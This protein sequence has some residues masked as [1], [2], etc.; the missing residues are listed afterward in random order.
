ML[1]A[2]FWRIVTMETHTTVEEGLL[3]DLDTAVVVMTVRL[4]NDVQ[5]KRFTVRPYRTGVGASIR[6]GDVRDVER[7]VKVTAVVRVVVFNGGL[8]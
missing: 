2:Y 7:R 3:T 6:E 1:P 5:L 8:R 4:L